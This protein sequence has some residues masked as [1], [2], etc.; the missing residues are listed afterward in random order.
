M[1]VLQNLRLSFFFNY[2]GILVAKKKLFRNR[3]PYNGGGGSVFF[4][5]LIL[6]VFVAVAF[7]RWVKCLRDFLVYFSCHTGAI[8][9]KLFFT[10][11]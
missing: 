5:R 8:L 3:I 10:I 9:N 4:V 1:A 11:H 6:I 2:L 7:N